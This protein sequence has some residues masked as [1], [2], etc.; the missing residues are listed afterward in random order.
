MSKSNISQKAAIEKLKS[1]A[2][3]IKTCMF[4][5]F[6]TENYFET[7][8][9]ATQKVDEDGTLWFFSD[10]NSHKNIQLDQNPK[11]QLIY[12]D[13]GSSKFMTVDGTAFELYDRDKIE[14]LWNPLVKAWFKDGKNDPNLMLI[15]VV[16]SEAYYWDTKHGKMISFLKIVSAAVTGKTDDDSV[17]GL[18]NL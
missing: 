1:I 18:L 7:R 9:M 12:A 8:P 17:E 4:C 14:E 16:P 11:V 5:T 3:D 10:R 15:K 2:D 13:P 6:T